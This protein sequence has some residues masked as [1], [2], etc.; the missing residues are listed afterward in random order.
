MVLW[1]FAAAFWEDGRVE[2]EKERNQVH[3]N[4]FSASA[5]KEENG[6]AV[7]LLW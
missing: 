1:P 4:P 2:S 6:V 7:Q 3:I 5:A